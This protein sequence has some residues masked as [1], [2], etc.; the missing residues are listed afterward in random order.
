MFELI[1]DNRDGVL[2]DISRIVTNVKYK[3]SRVGKAS[4]LEMTFLKNSPF[5]H[6]DFKYACGD[7]IR[8]KKDEANLFYGYIFSI[9]EDDEDAVRVIAYDQI[10]Y[11]MG[12]ETYGFVNLTATQMIKK[13]IED[14]ELTVGFFTDTKHV[15]PKF[16]EDNKRILD[17]ICKILDDTMMATSDLYV[18]Y[19]DFGKLTLQHIMDMILDVVIGDK[20]L[21]YAYK[22]K[23][24][25]DNETYNRIKLY[26][27]NKETGKREIFINQD[28]STIAKWGRLQYYQSVDEKMNIAQIN[29]SLNNLLK[30][31]NRESRSMSLDALGDSRI[32]AGNSIYLII[33]EKGIKGRFVVNECTHNFNGD[34]HTMSLELVVFG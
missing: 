30:L 27:D 16:L 26:K 32:R 31:K 2:W 10:R 14:N 33:E 13:I 23:T 4:S 9:D 6:H 29:T 7:V 22:S 3:T 25:I 8:F 11:L 5:A 17:I 28:S 20:S 21:L 18:F 1:L 19:D 34:E 24:S 15:I 12:N